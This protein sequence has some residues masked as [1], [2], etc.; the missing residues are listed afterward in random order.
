VKRRQEADQAAPCRRPMTYG[1][2]D[3]RYLAA[4]IDDLAVG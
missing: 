1:T 4:R 2:W 3:I